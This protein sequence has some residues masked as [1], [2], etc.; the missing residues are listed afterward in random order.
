M[1]D[2]PGKWPYD[3]VS[4]DLV[5]YRTASVSNAGVVCR[6]IPSVMDHITRYTL[7]IS[8]S[9]REATSK[10]KKKIIDRVSTTFGITEKFHFGGEAENK[11][12]CSL[13]QELGFNKTITTP[14]RPQGNSVSGR[15]HST[16]HVMLAMH[17]SLGKKTGHL[18][19]RLCRWR[20]IRP[21]TTQCMR[22]RTSCCSV[23]SPHCP[24]TSFLAY[25]KRIKLRHLKK[26]LKEPGKIYGWYSN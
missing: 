9:I 19:S 7:L 4:V 25:L 14:L 23:D 17:M 11:L 12:I 8:V 5:E 3:R 2:V 24:S 20:T 10:A 15:V 6:Y 26:N 21:T 18:H 13:Q 16:T 1:G 22:N